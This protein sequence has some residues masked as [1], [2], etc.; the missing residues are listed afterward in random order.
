M[1]LAE[2]VWVTV[3]GVRVPSHF[4]FPASIS[5]SSRCLDPRV[6]SRIASHTGTV[7]RQRK[8]MRFNGKWPP[9]LAWV[10]MSGT[11]TP[12]QNFITI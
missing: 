6:S 11:L 4:D 12:V 7:G 1:Q 8:S 5:A 3:S 2:Q 9:N 10:M